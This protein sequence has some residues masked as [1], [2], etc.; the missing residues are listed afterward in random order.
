MRKIFG[1][2]VSLSIII[3]GSVKVG[4]YYYNDRQVV[5]NFCS[6]KYEHNVSS[7]KECKNLSLQ[8]LVKVLTEEQ[9]NRYNKIV[10]L[11]IIK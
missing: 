7:Y 6:V 9:Q 8:N 1:V 2:I 4:I 3:L 10:P 11:E 5:E